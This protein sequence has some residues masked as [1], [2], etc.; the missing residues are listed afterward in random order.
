MTTTDQSVFNFLGEDE[1][2]KIISKDYNNFKPLL[3]FFFT[4]K[5]QMYKNIATKLTTNENI[6]SILKQ[7]GIEQ[8]I[9]TNWILSKTSESSH[10][11]YRVSLLLG[12]LFTIGLLP[13]SINYVSPIDFLDNRSQYLTA[14]LKR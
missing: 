14:E 12:Y 8:K 2:R 10:F 13:C 9:F 11:P 1:F 7:N 4:S 5:I 6:L 3:R